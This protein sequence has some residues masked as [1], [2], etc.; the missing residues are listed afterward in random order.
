MTKTFKVGDIV[1]LTITDEDAE[2]GQWFETTVIGVSSKCGVLLNLEGFVI[3]VNTG[4]GEG[5]EDGR[6]IEQGA[7]FEP[8]IQSF[9]FH[10]GLSY[11]DNPTDDDYDR[12][13]DEFKATLELSVWNRF[14]QL[15]VNKHSQG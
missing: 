5:N 9:C 12:Q 10:S 15:A 3:Y 11:A 4:E 7:R 14:D 6:T 2:K 13:W 1:R 8:A